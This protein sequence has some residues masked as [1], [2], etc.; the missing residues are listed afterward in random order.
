[1]QNIFIE[2]I[3]SNKNNNNNFKCTEKKLLN[4]KYENQNY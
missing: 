4:E 1:M 2:N 3:K